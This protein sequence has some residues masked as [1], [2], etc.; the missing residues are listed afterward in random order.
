MYGSDDVTPDHEVCAV[1]LNHVSSGA[2]YF[3]EGNYV[4]KIA[5]GDYWIRDE[6]GFGASGAYSKSIPTEMTAGVYSIGESTTSGFGSEAWG[7][8]G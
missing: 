5:R 2:M 6:E 4:L 7:G 3:P 8:L 1:Y